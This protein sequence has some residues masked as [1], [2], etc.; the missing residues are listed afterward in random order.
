M[1]RNRLIPEGIQSAAMDH[2]VARISEGIY[3]GDYPSALLDELTP[4]GFWNAV[5]RYA[6]EDTD[7]IRWATRNIFLVYEYLKRNSISYGAAYLF[8][9]FFTKP[10][11][12]KLDE[13]WREATKLG[14][15]DIGIMQSY[16]RTNPKIFREIVEVAKKHLLTYEHFENC[17][18]PEEE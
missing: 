8:C 14:P 5:R 12:E 3:Q 11:P 9:S 16:F 17:M 15:E 18:N 13:H 10:L 6:F 7:S 1:L 2:F 4:L